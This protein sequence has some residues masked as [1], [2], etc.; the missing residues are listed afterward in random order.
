MVVLCSWA[1]LSLQAP[2]TARPCGLAPMEGQSMLSVYVFLQ[3]RGGWMSLSGQSRVS[4]LWKLGLSHHSQEL[5]PEKQ[6]CSVRAVY[7][8]L[9]PSVAVSELSNAHCSSWTG[10]PALLDVPQPHF[11]LTSEMWICVSCHW[12]L[13]STLA[14]RPLFWQLGLLCLCNNGF[15]LTQISPVRMP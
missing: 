3:L 11:L 4:A 7:Q 2:G 8:W 10:A 5:W 14:A 13:P 9:E 1:F 15:S 6:G 12:S